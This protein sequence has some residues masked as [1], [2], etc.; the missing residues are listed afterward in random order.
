MTENKNTIQNSSEPTKRTFEKPYRF[1]CLRCGNCCKDKNTLVNLTFMDILRIQKYLD[2]DYK[3]LMEVIGFYIFENEPTE[4]QIKQ[5]VVPPILTQR[6]K[7][8]VALKKAADGRCV[9]LNE[10]NECKIYGARP[11]ICRTFP[12]HFHSKPIKE[13]QPHLEMEM[14]YA[15]KA[16]DYCAGIGVPQPVVAPAEWFK[17][18]EETVK[19]IL[20]E[21]VLINKWND[22]VKAKKI[23]PL[24]ENFIHTIM[25][26]QTSPTVSESSSTNKKNY[27][28]K[29]K[30]KLKE[31]KIV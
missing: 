9:Y 1:K 29:L 12:F 8:F 17:V 6:G 2:Y 26:L 18:G 27:Q 30:Q 15:T 19:N 10:N 4:D 13:P 24:A 25:E 11:N 14:S 23:E 31:Q 28:A 5:M 22:A 21:V 16:M 7:A 3:Q 20:A